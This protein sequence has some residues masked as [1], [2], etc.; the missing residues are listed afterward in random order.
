M[1]EEN[2]YI[3]EQEES[4][5]DF[6]KMFNDLL[7]HKKLYYKVLPITFVLSCIYLLSLPNYY[8]CTVK[9]S[10]E[11]SGGGRSNSLLNLASS[12]GMNIGGGLGVSTEAL[13]PWLY[14]ELMNSVDFKVDLFPVK[15]TIEPEE[16]GDPV[17][18][19]VRRIS[20]HKLHVAVRQ[21]PAC[22]RLVLVR[23]EPER[24][25]AEVVDRHDMSARALR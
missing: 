21:H 19:I 8:T 11:M 22:K 9:L 5:I 24:I 23:G 13:Y 15:V 16:E 7:K 17:R 18:Q 2:K 12:F 4:S 14:P 25:P 10:P 1:N 20:A 6:M 3:E